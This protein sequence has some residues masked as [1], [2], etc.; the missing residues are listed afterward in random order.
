MHIDQ[1]RYLVIEPTLL[2]LKKYD[3]KLCTKDAID[4]MHGTV[5]LEGSKGNDVYYHTQ[6]KGPARSPFQVEPNTMLDNY[7]N[8]LDYR[9]DFKDIIDELLIGSDLVEN[10]Y[11]NPFFACA[12]ARLVYWRSPVAIPDHY[13]GK[14]TIYKEIYNTVNGKA[15]L[16]KA[17]EV[18]R[19]IS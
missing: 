12:M 2:H 13:K 14:A 16:E 18:F 7:T 9:P 6:I 5:L 1:Y 17:I 8:Y 10:L 4:L 3:S 19:K 11:C 15:N